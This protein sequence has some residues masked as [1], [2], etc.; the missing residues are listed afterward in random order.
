[1]R[2]NLL[3]RPDW[4]PLALSL[5]LSGALFRLIPHPVNLAPVGA[6]SLFAGARLRGWQSYA[7]PLIIIAITDPIMGMLLGYPVFT[8]VT[9]VVCA[10]FL[11]YVWI[12]SRLRAT[13]NPWRIGGAA[14][15]GAAQFFVISNFGLWA[16]GISYPPTASGLWT[17]YLVGIPYFGRTLL[18]DLLYTGILFGLH[19][20]L[21]RRAFPDER[22]LKDP[23][24]SPS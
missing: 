14:L 5:A 21:S 20:W 22:V 16:S 1:M 3:E 24:V 8:A 11:I 10:S 19:A 9:P 7:V 18:A 23:L 6:L 12:G 17:C 4:R 15:F 2:K 13:E